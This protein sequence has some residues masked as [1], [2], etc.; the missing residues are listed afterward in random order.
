[1]CVRVSSLSERR[2]EKNG[3]EGSVTAKT[4]SGKATFRTAAVLAAVAAFAAWSPAAS[5]VTLQEELQVLLDKHPQLR[6]SRDGIS[7]AVTCP[8]GLYHILC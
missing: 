1:M 5:E 8:Q 3:L 6:A 7:V 4:R 2:R